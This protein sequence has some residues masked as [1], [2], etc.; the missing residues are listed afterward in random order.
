MVAEWREE[1]IIPEEMTGARVQALTMTVGLLTFVSVGLA[2]CLALVMAVFYLVV[3][4]VLIVLQAIAEVF[5]EM[6][7]TWA[8]ANPLLKLIILAAV[9]Y[10]G[11]RLYR[12]QKRGGKNA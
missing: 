6:A 5:S 9:F 1:M 8:G 2:A 12:K 4:F 10:G 11:Y 7:L 3:S